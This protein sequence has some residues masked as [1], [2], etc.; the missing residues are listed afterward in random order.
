MAVAALVVAGVV[1]A[2]ASGVTAYAAS[3]AQAD[4]ADYQRK[5]AEQQKKAAEEAGKVAEENQRQQ[6]QRVIAAARARAAGAGIAEDEGSSLLAQ[7]ESATNAELNARR[8]RWTTATRAAGIEAERVGY[9][10]AAKQARRQGY[11][12]AGASLLGGAAN[13]YG[14][15]S[16]GQGGGGGGT[17]SY[18][19][20][21]G[22]DFY[23]SD[24]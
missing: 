2:V 10:F 14:A 13:A 22:S 8:I 19:Y 12:S 5:V 7:M 24:K 20:Q 21:S 15:Y 6:D 16:Y 11:I 23:S 3:E 4:A 17:G 1:A 9:G 18:S